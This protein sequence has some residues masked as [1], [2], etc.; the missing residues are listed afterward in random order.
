MEG[1]TKSQLEFCENENI[2][3]SHSGSWN[4]DFFSKD[5]LGSIDLKKRRLVLPMWNVFWKLQ[6]RLVQLLKKEPRAQTSGSLF[7]YTEHVTF[8]LMV[9]KWLQHLQACFCISWKPYCIYFSWYLI[10]QNWW[11]GYL[12]L[13]GNLGR[14]YSNCVHCCSNLDCVSK[15]KRR[16]ILGR[17][18]NVGYDWCLIFNKFS[19]NLLISTIPIWISYG[20]V[21]GWP[22]L[23]IYLFICSFSAYWKLILCL[24]WFR[25][26]VTCV[27]QNSHGVGLSWRDMIRN[28]VG[29]QNSLMLHTPRWWRKCHFFISY[30]LSDIPHNLLLLGKY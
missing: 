30:H 7:W 20:E 23:F 21:Q 22:H 4:P 3:F 11:L 12:Q 17:S 8:S 9:A 6:F 16:K 13:H 18:T 15:T 24:V 25:H 28:V 27:E 1:N 2:T 14:E 26:W 19:Y 5:A 29:L 10:S